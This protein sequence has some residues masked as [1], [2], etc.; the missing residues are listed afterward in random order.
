MKFP[1]EKN[2]IIKMFFL[3]ILPLHGMMK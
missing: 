1:R 3:T 2:E